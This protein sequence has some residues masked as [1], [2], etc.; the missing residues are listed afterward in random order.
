MRYNDVFLLFER[1]IWVTEISNINRNMVVFRHI[2]I[3][4]LSS[5][6]QPG[7]PSWSVRIHLHHA[8]AV[9]VPNRYLGGGYFQPHHTPGSDFIIVLLDCLKTNLPCHLISSWIFCVKANA[10]IP[11]RTQITATLQI[12]P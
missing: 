12:H 4:H 3:Q 8:T 5:F 7:D 2:C 1:R 10:T 11:L 6:I 9:S